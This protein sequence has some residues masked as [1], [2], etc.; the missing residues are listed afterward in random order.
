MQVIVLVWNYSTF[1]KND[2]NSA[3][4]HKVHTILGR[5]N[6]SKLLLWA[7]ACHCLGYTAFVFALLAL[8]N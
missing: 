8:E 3:E 5:E 2:T 1:V 4:R 6:K 7:V